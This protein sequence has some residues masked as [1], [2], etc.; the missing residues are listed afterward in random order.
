M[1]VHVQSLQTYFPQQIK[2]VSACCE[3]TANFY[4]GSQAEVVKTVNT[5]MSDLNFEGYSV[6]VVWK[7]TEHS[8]CTCHKC[9]RATST[10]GRSEFNL[11]LEESWGVSWVVRGFFVFCFF[12]C[13]FIFLVGGVEQSCEN[14]DGLM[15][16]LI[17]DSLS[18]GSQQLDNAHLDT[19]VSRAGW[20]E[21]QL[22]RTGTVSGFLC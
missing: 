12:F 10:Q 8:H 17:C 6:Y 22:L 1:C 20:M 21:R 9:V 5:H 14:W 11:N 15:A 18:S 2:C 3:N 7:P 13:L 16:L 4:R 19:R